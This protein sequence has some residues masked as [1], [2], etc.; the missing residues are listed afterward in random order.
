MTKGLLALAL[1]ISTS[2]P[3]STCASSTPRAHS[4]VATLSAYPEYA[5]DLAST[6]KGTVVVKD[7]DAGISV[8]GTIGGAEASA[9]AGIHIHTGVSCADTGEKS[10]RLLSMIS[11]ITTYDA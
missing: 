1:A 7:T 9:A 6:I 5:G 11:C 4:A 3:T 10:H 2:L 8:F